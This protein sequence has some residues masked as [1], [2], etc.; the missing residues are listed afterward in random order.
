MAER[1]TQDLQQLEG[2]PTASLEAASNS[3]MDKME[4]TVK[5]NGEFFVKLGVKDSRALVLKEEIVIPNT[6]DAAED[7]SEKPEESI[8]HHY[9]VMTRNGFKEAFVDEKTHDEFETRLSHSEILGD[10]K[11]G[12][13]GSG[14]KSQSDVLQ[15][16]RYRKTFQEGD[17]YIK[18]PL[19]NIPSEDSIVIDIMKQSINEARIIGEQKQL[20]TIAKASDL[21]DTIWIETPI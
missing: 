13:F 6:P 7:K 4:A 18:V 16:M 21:L 8:E 12:F 20:T 10:S 3:L 15:F 14:D 5:K 19:L 17:S 1:P 9:V 11:E 2:E